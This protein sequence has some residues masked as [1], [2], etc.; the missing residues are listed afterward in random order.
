MALAITTAL[1]AV[2]AMPVANAFTSSAIM[3][4]PRCYTASNGYAKTGQSPESPLI[5]F[6]N[7]THATLPLA[8]LWG[9]L[10]GPTIPARRKCTLP[11]PPDQT[12]GQW[13]IWGFICGKLFSATAWAKVGQDSGA[14]GRAD[15]RLHRHPHQLGEAL[16][17]EPAHDARAV[18][19]HRALADVQL[20]AH[21][22]VGHA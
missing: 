11:Q 13:L 22:L 12:S 7:S 5:L 9:D 6:N 18:H 16:D 15:S 1:T 8:P 20:G 14:S 4:H 17:T 10:L 21:G 3:T 19:L 2:I